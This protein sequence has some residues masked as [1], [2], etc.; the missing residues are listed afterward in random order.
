MLSR[1]FYRKLAAGSLVAF[2]LAF[3]SAAQTRRS[4]VEQPREDRSTLG[5]IRGR[6]VMPGGFFVSENIKVTLLTLRETMATVYTDNQGQFE[7]PGLVPGNYKLE[8]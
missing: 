3:S 1:N 7:F 8:V 2:L 5:S 6:I 4:A